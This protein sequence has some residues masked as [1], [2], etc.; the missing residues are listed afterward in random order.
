MINCV[1]IHIPFCEKKC[2]YCSFCS[3]SLLKKK[4]IYL[5]ALLREIKY[6][7]KKEELKTLY[8]GGGT[9]SLLEVE[10][11]E[12]IIKCFNLKENAEVTLELN[13]HN[14]NLEK[15][16][17]LKKTKVNRLSVGVQ[18]FDD[19][20]LKVIGRTHT[21][22][23]IFDTLKNIE[24]A[25][26]NNFSIDLMYGLPNQTI[27]NWQKTL[28]VAIQTNAKHISLYGLKIEDGTYFSKHPPKSLPS[29]DLQ[30][31]MYEIAIEKLSKNFTHYEFS[32][33]AINENYISQ[34][35]SAYW[36]CE[37]YYGFGLS[38]SG[39]IKNK[40]Y[41]N[42]FNFNEYIKNPIQKEYEI[43]SKEEQIEEEIFLGLRLT[44]GIDFNYINQKFNIDTYKKYKKEF[45]KYLAQKLM[46]KTKNG[47]KLTT[48]GIL[49]SNEILCDFINC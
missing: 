17:N 9:P 36:N 21:S 5:E 38:A 40:R 34:H 15:L 28:D 23:E 42:T 4:N 12:K 18:N 37:K 30:A 20:I 22:I 24:L 10:D 47:I 26:F 3:F 41:T 8:F 31:K 39:Y 7:Y 29:Q 14:I 49:L 33:F 45:D 11:I 48:K 32:N 43:L 16:K 46:E 35:N 19:E 2:N 27:K 13:P 6:F 25:G 44:K 1:Y